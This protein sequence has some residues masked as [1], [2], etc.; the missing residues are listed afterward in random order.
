MLDPKILRTSIAEVQESLSLR[1]Y[2]LNT[3]AWEEMESARKELQGSTEELKAELNLI[4]KE[5]GILKSENKDSSDKEKQASKL[6]QDIKKRNKELDLVLRNL[7]DY[8]LDIPNLPDADCP[9]GA[10]EEDNVE[11]RTWGEIKEFSY[12]P[13]D[14]QL[15][16]EEM[17]LLDLAA[18][19]KIA[20]ARFSVLRGDLA[21]L[22]R[23]LIQFMLESH[24]EK[25]YE[26]LYVPYVVNKDSLI[27]TGQLP[28]FEEDLFKLIDERE[29][30][31]TSTAEVPVTNLIRNE[32]LESKELP[33][34]WVCHTPSFRS[35]AGS[36]GKDTRGIMRQ[37]QFE[38][39]EL[40]QV[41][42]AQD[43]TDALE[44]L[45]SDAEEILQKLNLP[46]RVVS[47]CAGDLGFSSSKTYDIE[48]WIPSQ[49]KYREISSCSNFKDFQSRRMKARWKN[50][51]T[52]KNEFVHTLNGSGLAVGRTLLAIMENYQEEDGKIVIPEALRT[53][54]QKD[55]I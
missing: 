8:S 43:S 47:L 46:Y 19:A 20:G 22:H 41:V 24:L 15:L 5:I 33:K 44:E 50:P 21:K 42:E 48:V 17:G 53:L 39:V 16:G 11:I 7:E 55:T 29:L 4:S 32:I 9:H 30:Y 35:E 2:K 52:K 12:E 13:K 45:T 1:G 38:K 36:Y 3:D 26:E 49:K 54:M 51:S 40:V 28:K 31:L 6:T 25:G 23:C 37:H 18:A 10:S 27:G 34:K 14:H